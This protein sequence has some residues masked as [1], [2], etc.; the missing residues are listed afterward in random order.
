MRIGY[1]NS[2]NVLYTVFDSSRPE[3]GYTV[4]DVIT[5][6]DYFVIILPVNVVEDGKVT[7]VY[8]ETRISSLEAD[9]IISAFRRHYGE[10]ARSI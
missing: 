5:H 10:D 6:A 8:R 1:Y 4:H 9:A 2:E 7:M 3:E